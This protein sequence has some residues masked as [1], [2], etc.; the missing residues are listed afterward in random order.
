MTQEKKNI[1]PSPSA[2]G[3]PLTGVDT[4]VHLD[5]DSMLPDLDAVCARARDA[6]IALMGQ[7]FLGPDAWDA[8]APLFA[9]Y[10]EVFFILGVHPCHADTC[11]GNAIA[12]MKQAFMQDTRLKAV[13]EIGLD[14]YW[15]AHPRALQKQV[16]IKQL[17]MAVE[18]GVPVVI[19]SR[20]AHDD[21]I[22]IL[23]AQG[24]KGRPVLWHCF[25]ADET[26][27]Q[28]IVANGWHISIPGPITYPKSQALRTALSSIPQDRLV[29]ETD[30][31]YLT[32]IPWRGKRNE[33]A[34]A[35]FTG[36]YVA[37]ILNIPLQEFWTRCGTNARAFF[38]LP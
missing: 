20:D 26:L 3:L 24:F 6:G 7:V 29:L 38:G 19:H 16:F 25:N 2:L 12:R 4:H 8:H 35:A 18:L 37:D 5:L 15:D 28:R 13:G 22:A 33:P 14:Y 30:C 34:M 32:P 23:E 21:T 10:P 17:E 9:D 31:P 11:G 36:A 27:A 1:P